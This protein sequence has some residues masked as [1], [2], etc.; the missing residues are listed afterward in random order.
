MDVVGVSVDMI[1]KSVEISTVSQHQL[2]FIVD[3]STVS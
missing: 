2:G 1:V 3:T